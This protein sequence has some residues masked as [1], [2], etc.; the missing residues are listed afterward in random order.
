[1]RLHL[2]FHLLSIC[3]V[4]RYL[5]RGLPRFILKKKIKN[6]IIFF[7]EEC[8]EGVERDDGVSEVIKGVRIVRVMTVP[9]DIRTLEK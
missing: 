9:R 5:Q 3:F 6:W 4:L 2:R 8:E 7:F 1:M